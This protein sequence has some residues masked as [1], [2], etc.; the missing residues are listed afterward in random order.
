MPEIDSTRFSHLG[1]MVIGFVTLKLFCCFAKFSSSLQSSF[2]S[3][4]SLENCTEDL[5]FYI[6]ILLARRREG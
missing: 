3:G 2:E 1:L 6:D 5:S 4:V